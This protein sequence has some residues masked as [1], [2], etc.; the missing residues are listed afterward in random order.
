MS[1]HVE[2][3]L[4]LSRAAAVRE[5]RRVSWQR[6]L[7]TSP[8]CPIEG[9][10]NG[11]KDVHHRRLHPASWALAAA[12]VLV[13]SAAAQGVRIVRNVNVR[14]A[15][16]ARATTEDSGVPVE[17]F[18]NPNLD[19][20]LRRAQDFLQREDYAAAI[21]V[22]QDVV[23]GH[24]LEVIGSPGEAPPAAAPAPAADENR[25]DGKS[26]TPPDKTRTELDAS[27][28]VFSADGR[29][30]RPVRRLCHELLARLPEVGI[31][32][33]RAN[34]EVA[35]AELLERAQVDGS[36]SALEEVA[37]RYFI[38]LPAGRA[39]AA[40]ADR[41]MHDGRYRAAVQVLRDLVQ[42]YPEQNRRRLGIDDVWCGFKAA[43]CLR[44]AGEAGAARDEA[45]DLAQRHPDATLRIS[46]ELQAV[47]DLP[48]NELFADQVLDLTAPKAA[49]TVSCI[50]ATT[51]ELVPVWQYRF[52][53][54]DPY[55]DP[56]AANN[57]RANFF[58]DDGMRATTMPHANRYGPATWLAFA[59]ATAADAAP[60]DLRALFFE[61]YRLRIAA[62]DSGL[63]LATGDGVDR[64]PVPR[65]NHP[66]V[67]IAAVDFAVLRPVADE[68][69]LYAVLGHSRNT[70]SSAEVL[71]AS[72][73]VAYDRDTMQRAWSSADWHDGAD[74][75]RDVTFLAAP[76]VFGERLLLP[77][78]R[79]DV[80]E[81]RCLDRATGRPLWHT[82][83]HAGGSPFFK[84]PGVPVVVRGGIALMATNAGCVAAVDA[85]TGDLRWI[86]RYERTDP[87]RTFPRG[88][89]AE[90]E[91][92]MRFGEQFLQADLGGF[93]PNDLV[94]AD[95]L[96]ILAACD[97]DLL[98]CLDG[99]SGQPVWMLDATT[100]HAPYGKLRELVGAT[101]DDLYF[102]ADKALVCIGL[103]GGL[104][105]WAH[106]LPT[107]TTRKS[108]GRGR[109]LVLGDQVL[110][111]GDREILVF[112][113][114]DQRPMRRLAL[115][116]FDPSRDPL[117]G[118]FDLT[119]H[120]ALLAVG[121]AGGVEMLSSRQALAVEAATATDASR[122]ARLLVMAGETAAAESLLTETQR[123]RGDDEQ[124][125]QRTEQLLQLVRHRATE[126]A[127]AG[128]LAPA[129]AALDGIADLLRER[130]R[131]LEWHL[132]RLDLCA[133]AGDLRRHEQEQQRLYDYME[134]R[135]VEAGK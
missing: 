99:A 117:D 63:M 97:S 110:V 124:R 78:I 108:A 118:S 105:R 32:L 74:G 43:L 91:G 126:L 22:L 93:L 16:P 30:Y 36:V 84:A 71:K 10:P 62:A 59:P 49:P 104:V 17:L 76:T 96:V 88:K 57:N 73:L 66:R 107:A 65:E 58:V 100:R 11:T 101:A 106:E 130:E 54:P 94:V 82:P 67:R 128:Q 15:P 34:Y 7:P 55:R 129:L 56:K 116:A 39:L 90:G 120:G 51:D 46:G 44:L 109:G 83:I 122:R 12:V 134:G 112:D 37:N 98:L 68:R 92:D 123:A 13:G 31:E 113:A 23:E 4:I 33:Y 75:L 85:Y 38:T 111:P 26:A 132:A 60:G 72:E 79:R 53:D 18:E 42:I 64:P 25:D 3:E 14:L 125:A 29:L 87:L 131:R 20:Y 9:A 24:T 35:A 89:R 115:P 77:S 45:M 28:A 69:H 21:Q 70:T 61:H 2:S 5:R 6:R 133:E 121:F 119:A 1:H 40:L 50:D 48:S 135:N 52:A 8:P 80:Y 27:R 95:G 114:Q 103:H 81:L 47:K 86:R 19:R 41:L 102:V 127:Q